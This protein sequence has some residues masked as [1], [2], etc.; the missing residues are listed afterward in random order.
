MKKKLFALILAAALLVCAAAPAFAAAPAIRETDYEGK[1][2]VEVEFNSNQVQYR[3]LKVV[4]K[5][6]A[7][8]T[9]PVKILEK[10]ND[11]LTFKVDGVQ[12]GARYTYTI[13]GIRAGRSGSFGSAKGSFKTPSDTPEIKKVE[14]D[15]HD[16]ELEIEFATRVQFKSPKVVVKDASGK[17]LA[18]SKLEK[19][20]D[21]IEVRVKGLK[22]GATYTVS[23]S[24]VRVYGTGKYIKVSK[25]VK[26]K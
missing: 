13:S 3:N 5:N 26:I 18:V 15:A 22:R 2:V 24:G 16:R 17:A 8:K 1:G 19:G 21:D 12:S 11:D 20:L 9:C 7:G 25:K 23:V 4:V 14:Y 10:D 6:A